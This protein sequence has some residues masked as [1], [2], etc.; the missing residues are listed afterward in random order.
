MSD[1]GVLLVNLGTP[2]APTARALRR[3]L[4]EFLSDPRVVEVP[5]PVWW[6]VLRAFVLPF[7]PR[8]SAEAYAAIWDTERDASPLRVATET[9]AEALAPKLEGIEVDWGMRYGNPSLASRIEQLME[10][11]VRRLLVW[12]LYPQYSASTTGSVVDGVGQVLASLRHQPAVR[13]VPP[14]FD[15]PTYV[16]G[17]ASQTKR[18]LSSLDWEPEAL[19]AS[20]HGIPVAYAERGDPYPTQCEATAAALRLALELPEERFLLTF[21]S[22]FGPSEWLTPATDHTLAE[23]PDRGIR[24]V[25]VV[26]P[27]FAADC[28]ETLE[29]LGLRGRDAFQ[30]AGGEKFALLPCLNAGPEAIALG[31]TLLRRELAGWI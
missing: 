25:A 26:A 29:E 3:Y 30:A 2:D 11:G 20:F 5:R 8:K 21:Q 15:E 1:V 12:P 28:V 18:A 22:R 16:S 24:R 10:R 13:F 7:R 27:G 31:E 6:F 9:L 14:Y 17:V 4:R 23:L 19:L